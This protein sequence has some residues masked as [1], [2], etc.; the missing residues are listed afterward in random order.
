MPDAARRP[1][2]SPGSRSSA[3]SIPGLAIAGA[4]GTLAKRFQGTPA[5]IRLAAKTGWINGAAAMVGRIDGGSPAPTR[6]FALVFNG[7]F[8]WAHAQAVQ[9]RVVAA[10]AGDLPL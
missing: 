10:L 2:A 7:Q 1:R 6:R 8:G 3:S 9:D 5:E 4:T